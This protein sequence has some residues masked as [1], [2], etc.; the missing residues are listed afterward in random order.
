MGSDLPLDTKSFITRHIQSV[1]QLE[2]LLLL[3][4]TRPRTWT[5]TALSRETRSNETAVTHSVGRL[6]DTGLAIRA[7]DA[8]QF[9]T[10]SPELAEQTDLLAVIYH[11]RMAKVIEF[12]YQRP[13]FQIAD[14]SEAFKFRKRR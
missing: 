12:I 4:K 3:A 1:E 11:H 14:F 6:V 5:A 2:I 10:E 7:G 13:D 8:Y 9:Q